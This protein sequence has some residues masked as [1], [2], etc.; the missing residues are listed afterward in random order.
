MGGKEL[1]TLYNAMMN[2]KVTP[3]DFLIWVKNNHVLGRKDYNAKH[4]FIIYGWK[5]KH[6][7][8]GPHRVTILNYDKPHVSDLHPTMK[9]IKLLAQLIQDGSKE[10]MVV[11][12][13]FLGSGSTL[14]ACEQTNRRCFGM[15]IDPLYAEVIIMRWEKLT[16][17]KAQKI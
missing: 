8:Y 3:S 12:D 17:R 7:F 13:P 6:K 15:E 5:G 2:Q 4:E 14:I 9:P 10:S 16:G 11:Y 1:M